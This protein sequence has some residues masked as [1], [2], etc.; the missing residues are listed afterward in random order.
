MANI[1]YS[2]I[3]LPKIINFKYLKYYKTLLILSTKLIYVKTT[4]IMVQ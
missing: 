2:Q 1:S 3:N 4:E